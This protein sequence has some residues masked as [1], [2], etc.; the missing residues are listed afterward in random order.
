MN[1]LHME[2]NTFE[3][4]DEGVQVYGSELMHTRAEVMV[5]L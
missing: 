1:Q 2:H 3:P 5:K 4:N